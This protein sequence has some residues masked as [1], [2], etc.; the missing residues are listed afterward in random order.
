[1]T[2]N[3]SHLLTVS[4]A[5]W[6]LLVAATYAAN[7]ASFLV[8]ENT[9]SVQLNSLEDAVRIRASICVHKGSETHETLSSTFPTAIL[10]KMKTEGDIY[11]GL[12]NGVCLVIAIN[13]GS[14]AYWE[15]K[16]SVNG[17]CALEW[18]GGIFRKAPQG[19]ATKSDS[20]TLCT[21]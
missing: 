3:A 21:L 16:M 10:I 4:L 2:L 1:M 13:A 15:K 19:F 9:P 18:V 12:R 14:W 8:V 6:A 20:G 11:W 5:F 17:D 7:L